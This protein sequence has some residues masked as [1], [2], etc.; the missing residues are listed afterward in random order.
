MLVIAILEMLVIRSYQ[1]RKGLALLN[2]YHFTI[3]QTYLY[4]STS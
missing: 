3:L 2:P 1:S 4:R